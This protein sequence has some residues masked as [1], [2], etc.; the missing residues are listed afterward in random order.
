[1]V[2]VGLGNPDREYVGTR[3]NVGFEL[4]EILASRWG[5]KRFA[6]RSLF[7]WTT[8][9][10]AG[11]EVVL[12]KPMTYMNRSGVAVGRFLGEREWGPERCLI[13]VD[14]MALEVGRIRFRWRG[15]DGGHQGLASV[16][17]R[18]GTETYSRLRIGVGPAPA[19]AEWSDFVLSPF[20]ADERRI[21][22]ETF[23]RAADGV[24]VVIRDGIERAM[25]LYND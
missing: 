3:H 22:D 5:A 23:G 9:R 12:L 19:S 17:E 4:V 11:R 2:V 18:L 1:M 25:S 6:S 21:I 8:A 13:V 15:G 24:E 16:E 7:A 10:F 20:T 14:D